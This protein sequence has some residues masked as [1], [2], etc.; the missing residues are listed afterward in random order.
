MSIVCLSLQD[1][2]GTKRSKIHRLVAESNPIISPFLVIVRLL[3]LYCVGNFTIAIAD[4]NG[5]YTT[6]TFN[7]RGQV[8]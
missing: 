8:D 3:L 1:L 7:S 5:R 2:F 6:G 4:N